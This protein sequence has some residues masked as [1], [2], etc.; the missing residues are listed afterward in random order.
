M[1]DASCGGNFLY[2][3]HEEVWELFELLGEN[4]HLHATSS[5]FDLPR[6]LGSKG[7]FY[8]VTHSI[9]LSSKVYALS[10]KFDQLL[11]IKN[12]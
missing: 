4:S 8:E 10:K 2:K 6:K 9:D 1:V 11:C 7:G 3:T 5:H 12:G